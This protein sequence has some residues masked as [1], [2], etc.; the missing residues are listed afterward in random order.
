MENIV[1]SNYKSLENLEISKLKR[2]N[3]FT[4]KNNTGKSTILEALSLFAA[5]GSIQWIHHLLDTRGEIN[6]YKEENISE[7][8]NIK[9]LSAFFSHRNVGFQNNDYI[10]IHSDNEDLSFRF[11]KFIQEDVFEKN[12][13]G[14]DIV[15]GKKR[16]IINNSD[17]ENF[18]LGFEVKFDGDSDMIPLDRHL[19]RRRAL[20]GFSKNFHLINAKGDD[21]L[22]SSSLWDKITLSEKEELVI[23]ALKIIEPRITRLSFIG[24]DNYRSERYPIVKL[25]G[26]NNLYPLK[27][28]GDGINRI[29]NLILALV[30][31]DNGY[32]LIDEFENGLHF[33]VQEKLW[34]VIFEI[35]NKL[36][37]QVFV[38]THSNDSINAFANVLSKST[39]YEGSLHRLVRINDKVKSN[40]FSE[41]E[42]KE[43]SSQHINLR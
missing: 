27:A 30:N 16:I 34:E 12:P 17:I 38:T 39:E 36:N 42:I 7:D 10:K 28:M 24:E 41:E 26:T 15:I 4:G 31:S 3:L 20:S 25:E 29:L 11:V 5:K 40:I 35:S 8:F 18:S 32:L 2:V 21:I 6:N 33:S 43:A 1:I 14:K 19:F 22:N 9:I 13:E 23:D 37:T